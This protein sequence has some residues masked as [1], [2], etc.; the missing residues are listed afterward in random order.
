[1]AE[2]DEHDP[3][4]INMLT[5]FAFENAT[6]QDS[7]MMSDM[8]QNSTGGNTAMLMQSMVAYNPEMVATVY[9]DLAEQDYDLFEHIESAKMEMHTDHYYD[10]SYDPGANPYSDPGM[11][12]DMQAETMHYQ[13][14][15]FDDLKGER[16][17]EIMT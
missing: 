13:E 10:P 9:N 8:M 12:E 15:S 3:S 4:M 11:P 17:S 14:Q 2:R 6:E 7:G 1:M 16:F 5:T